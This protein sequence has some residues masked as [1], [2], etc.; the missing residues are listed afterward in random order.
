MNRDYFDQPTITISPPELDI[1]P[2]SA[3]YFNDKNTIVD[4]GLFIKSD[5]PINISNKLD[6]HHPLSKQWIDQKVQSAP[7]LRHLAPPP[8][9]SILLKKHINS[10]PSIPKH[11]TL[12]TE[13]EE[14]R[15]SVIT[16]STE[17]YDAVEYDEKMVIH[18]ESPQQ[19]K[20]HKQKRRP[21]FMSRISSAYTNKTAAIT[22][23]QIDLDECRYLHEGIVICAIVSKRKQQVEMQP[24]VHRPAIHK[25][26]LKWKP[27][28]AVITQSGYLQ[29]F[30]VCSCNNNNKLLHMFHNDKKP[31][32]TID[33]YPSVNNKLFEKSFLVNHTSS[34]KK[35]NNDYYKLSLMSPIDFS[36]SLTSSHAA[37]YFQSNSI[38]VSQHW[39][40]SLYTALPIQSKLALPQNVDLVIPELSTCIRL[41]VSEFIT[42]E[43]ENVDLRKVR[44]SAL[45]LLH[46]NG[47][48]PSTWN[49]RTV[50]LCWKL[51]NTSQSES[52]DWAL[53]PSDDEHHIAYLIEPRLIEKTHELQIRY[54]HEE[55]KISSPP[56][57]V[58][59]YLID[60]SSSS[61]IANKL[62]LPL[63][64]HTL[65]GFM[66]LFESKLQ[67]TVKKKNAFCCFSFPNK[68]SPVD[69]TSME[70]SASPPLS[71]AVGIIDVSKI[72]EITE[73]AS[74]DDGGEDHSLL[75][76]DEYA[77]E[78]MYQPVHDWSTRLSS[79]QK[80][81]NPRS[82]HSVLVWKKDAL[83]IN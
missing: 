48:R 69:A 7:I 22:V 55:K 36:W 32:Y 41:P 52:L 24:K 61:K 40:R 42:V 57:A 50:G 81:Y 45:V 70:E 9:S 39:Y 53:K 37:F 62:H 67:L 44:D 58:Q 25:R 49:K 15:P 27:Y 28:R 47:N 56:P 21:S 43:D 34:S 35:G 76:L 72:T 12:E 31:Q 71:T 60:K 18:D 66:F 14:R 77:F 23:D 16:F 17:Y 51:L 80:Y 1:T 74:H 6:S 2:D 5:P 20:S 33:L 3:H 19:R 30:N 10:S 54:W 83:Y 38:N 8:P 63:Y 82:N 26:P 29:L 13:A 75:Q 4:D 65:D 46:R 79:I 64:A 11:V 59:G 68:T 78:I 73:K